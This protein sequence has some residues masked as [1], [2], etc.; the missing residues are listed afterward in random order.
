MKS[1][2]CSVFVW[3]GKKPA[4]HIVGLNEYEQGCVL[5]LIQGLHGGKIRALEQPFE[6]MELV[7]TQPKG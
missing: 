4:A 2:K 7:K 5:Q 3:I 6:S 1:K